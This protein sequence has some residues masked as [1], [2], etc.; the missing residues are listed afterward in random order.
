MS[1]QRE[2]I[3]KKTAIAKKKKNYW[4]EKYNNWNEKFSRT[5]SIFEYTEERIHDPDNTTIEVIQSDN[6]TKQQYSKHHIGT[7]IDTGINGIE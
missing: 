1:R 2:N 6:T 5:L 4:A 7:K 3:N